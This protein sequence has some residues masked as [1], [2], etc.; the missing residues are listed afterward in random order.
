M[1]LTDTA[2]RRP[3]AITMF[4]LIVVT[5]G[6]VGFRYLPVDLLPEIEFPA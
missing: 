3:V 5:F 6:V 4:Y 1:S 2:I